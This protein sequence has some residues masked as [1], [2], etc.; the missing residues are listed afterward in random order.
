MCHQSD[1]QKLKRMIR[2]CF[3]QC[4]RTYNS[5]Y[6]L[7]YGLMYP[8]LS[9]TAGSMHV[10]GLYIL[11]NKIDFMAPYSEKDSRFRYKTPAYTCSSLS[12]KA[13]ISEKDRL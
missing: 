7:E 13:L 6:G 12:S 11:T 9:W 1:G 4:V 5:F 10:Q 8:L 2:P 3:G